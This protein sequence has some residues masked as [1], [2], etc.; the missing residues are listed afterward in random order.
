M[1]KTDLKGKKIIY[2]GQ[3]FQ[4]RRREKS[5]SAA[6]ELRDQLFL[7]LIKKNLN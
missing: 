7:F 6:R 3:V 2:I 5:V 1:A 4:K